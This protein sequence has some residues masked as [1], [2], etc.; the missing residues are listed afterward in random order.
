MEEEVAALL[1]RKQAIA[2]LA[3]AGVVFLAAILLLVA[4]VVQKCSTSKVPEDKDGPSSKEEATVDEGPGRGY[5]WVHRDDDPPLIF[6]ADEPELTKNEKTGIHHDKFHKNQPKG[7]NHEERRGPHGF[8]LRLLGFSAD[9]SQETEMSTTDFEPE[10]N[11]HHEEKVVDVDTVDDEETSESSRGAA[12]EK[13]FVLP[14]HQSLFEDVPLWSQVCFVLWI[15]TFG[16]LLLVCRLF[17][18]LVLVQVF[19]LNDPTTNDFFVKWILG[20][21]IR[22][23]KPIGKRDEQDT[24][25]VIFLTSHHHTYDLGFVRV[26]ASR[27]LCLKPK[28]M[29]HPKVFNSQMIKFL[30]TDN[31]N[32][33]L[34]TTSGHG[35]TFLDMFHQWADDEESKNTSM[36]VA[37]AGMTTHSKFITPMYYKYFCNRNTA[38]VIVNVDTTAAFGVKLRNLTTDSIMAEIVSLMLPWTKATVTFHFDAVPEDLS[39]QEQIDAL[40]KDLYQKHHN[41]SYAHGWTQKKRRTI[42]KYI[43]NGEYEN[44]Q[45]LD[46]FRQDEDQDSLTF[47]SD[48]DYIPR[49]I[50]NKLPNGIHFVTNRLVENP[51]LIGISDSE[52]ALVDPVTP[53]D[54][55]IAACHHI[56]MARVTVGTS[57]DRHEVKI[58][59][60][61]QDLG[62]VA[63]RMSQGFHHIFIERN[64]ILVATTLF[65]SGLWPSEL[66]LLAQMTTMVQVS[67]LTIKLWINRPRPVWLSATQPVQSLVDDLQVDSSFPSGHSSFFA[68][69]A[70]T[71]FY[72]SDIISFHVQMILM[73]LWVA[74]SLGRVHVG[75]H[76]CTDVLVGSGFAAVFV[77]VFYAAGGDDWLFSRIGSNGSYDEYAERGES[78]DL[79][80]GWLKAAGMTEAPRKG[81]S[82]VLSLVEYFS[83]APPSSNSDYLDEA[84]DEL[85]FMVRFTLCLVALQVLALFGT[86]MLRPCPS[87]L[88]RDTFFRNN[89]SRL[90]DSK[91][92]MLLEDEEARPCGP[93]RDFLA[94]FI[95]VSA[96]VFWVHPF[97]GLLYVEAGR[98]PF[99]DVHGSVRFFGSMLALSYILAVVVP[100]RK[101]CSKLFK[102]AHMT[103]FFALVLIYMSML[104]AASLFCF[105][106]I[107]AIL[108]LQ[109]SGP[110]DTCAI[111]FASLENGIQME[112]AFKNSTNASGPTPTLLLLPGFV[113]SWQFYGTMIDEL[114]PNVQVFSPSLRGCGNSDKPSS[115]YSMEDYTED[116]IQFLDQE[117]S[118]V[119]A[120][121]LT[122]VGHSMGGLVAQR[123][124]M[125]HP[126]RFSRL[127]LVGTSGN[128]NPF[129]NQ[130]LR[131]LLREVV[132]QDDYMVP[133]YLSLGM[134]L[135][136]LS[137][138]RDN[139]RI[140]NIG[141]RETAKS[142]SHVWQLSSLT[143]ALTNH[144]GN[145]S[146][147]EMPTMVAWGTNDNVFPRQDQMDLLSAIGTN[148]QFKVYE[149][150]N[151]DLPWEVSKELAQ[152]IAQFAMDG[153]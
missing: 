78:E 99:D 48:L 90:S 122:L 10:K 120:S 7:A 92:K 82:L 69:L 9:A 119:E 96:V 109:V 111:K 12:A 22:S 89:I 81:S 8:M 146:A 11:R 51:K 66:L 83:E 79:L 47:D 84:K 142:P 106:A 129:E 55:F 148:A 37:P 57:F 13:R 15:C 85:S 44:I 104:V 16:P 54:E 112:Y 123:L 26:A 29:V 133:K 127:V 108:T 34:F 38:K 95:A 141:S 56:P 45:D 75:A 150:A 140:V 68:L 41:K 153:F 61:L 58:N 93:S 46:V 60:K 77:S 33:F 1:D 126:E 107:Q 86:N 71:S 130:E 72:E 115:G 40:V 103:R 20:W 74:G 32:Q 110:C 14:F 59:E 131:D 52:I 91:R 137:I 128:P 30:G 28:L 97:I 49:G 42:D 67:L 2:I 27:D 70:I 134:R 101:I 98:L 102:K 25:P 23:T 64:L 105:F 124:A 139:R 88:D 125:L 21:R 35:V 18:T 36:V 80:Q 39:T 19:H 76:Y 50:I 132:H 43:R 135:S 63:K 143:M 117:L 87:P 62:G 4:V 118:E 152:D 31:R 24:R 6:D 136:L 147:I 138:Q 100:C 65:A 73:S 121:N 145:L 144:L 151:H 53:A 5:S 3:I 116:V 149:D 94:P 114:P 113:S 17:S